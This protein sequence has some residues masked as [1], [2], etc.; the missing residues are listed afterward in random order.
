MTPVSPHLRRFAGALLSGMAIATLGVNLAPGLYYDLIDWTPDSTALSWLFAPV[1]TPATLVSGLLMPFFFL[2]IGKELW[3][4]LIFERGFMRG[5]SAALPLM[6]SLGATLGGALAWAILTAL[7]ET[8]EEAAG[9]T[10]WIVPFGSD[11]VLAFLFGRLIFGAGHPALQL[12]LFLAV[13]S[14]LLG[15]LVGGAIAPFSAGASGDS[16]RL[17]WLI[18]PLGAALGGYFGLTRPAQAAAATEVV[19]QRAA[20]LWP[21]LALGTV[22]W[23]GVAASGLP[24]A[25]GL[26]PLLPA[27]PHAP[28]S[29]GLFAEAEG[30]L[31]DP[32]NRLAH[33][34]MQPLMLVL[35]LFAL[36]HGG[37]DLAAISEPTSWITLG[38]FWV[39]KPLGIMAALLAAGALGLALPRGLVRGDLW[40]IA[41]LMGI[42]FSV[43]VLVVGAALPGG[44]MTE[45]ARLGF[46]LTVLAGPAMLLLARKL[47]KAPPSS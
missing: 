16:L 39:G 36:T 13:L 3:E 24:P 4:A 34:L 2:L 33:H 19:H 20:H 35:F 10:G 5:R 30:F 37:L 28:R 7:L 21:W 1:L 42:G 32:L 25:L 38:A 40:L 47:R 31:T 43:P 12:L 18:L 41:G 27:M 26:L 11:V 22:A 9:A 23:L 6:M 44:A 17:I 8:A 29:F 14:D 45:G 46:G 15:L